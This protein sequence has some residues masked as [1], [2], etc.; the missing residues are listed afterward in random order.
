MSD[1]VPAPLLVSAPAP[2]N[3]TVRPSVVPLATFSVPPP[4]LSVTARDVSKAARGRERATFEGQ[5]AYGRAERGISRDLKRARRE[6]RAAGIAVGPRQDNRSCP[7]FCERSAAGDGCRNGRGH[8]SAFRPDT[9]AGPKIK[10]P[11]ST[12]TR[13]YPR[14][15]EFH[16]FRTPAPPGP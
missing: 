12:A 9:S 14:R 13:L 16:G 15:Q 3:D 2:D 5:A 7:D 6:H 10:R 4:A 8:V 1:T 11:A